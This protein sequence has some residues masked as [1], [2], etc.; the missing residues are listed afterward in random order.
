MAGRLGS[1]I[2]GG[3]V[4]AIAA[5][6]AA[7][8]AGA[9]TR[10]LVADKANEAWGSA[11][12][13]DAQGRGQQAY[14]SAADV[15]AAAYTRATSAAQDV[16]HGGAAAGTYVPPEQND[17]LRVKIEAARARIAAQVAKNAEAVKEAAAQIEVEAEAVAEDAK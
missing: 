3:A 9:E 5:L 15:A 12:G 1:F 4:G 11:Q 6:L 14:Q 10:T 17:E 7:P 8:R 2:I 16:L 13:Y